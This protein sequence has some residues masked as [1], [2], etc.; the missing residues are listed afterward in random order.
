MAQRFKDTIQRLE[1]CEVRYSV[2]GGY[3]AMLHGSALMTQD[4]DVVIDLSPENLKKLHNAL[5]DLNPRHRMGAEK[6]AFTE[7]DAADP[8]W[9]NLYLTTDWG[10]LDC[11]GEVAGIGSFEA[12]LARS[13]VMD[14][15]DFQLRILTLDALIEAK[16]AIGRPKDIHAVHELEAIWELREKS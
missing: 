14:L 2:I 3:A 6:R 5:Q 4:A 8:H 1:A 11:L 9:K 13:E 15:G 10:Q 7:Q 12:C 16:R